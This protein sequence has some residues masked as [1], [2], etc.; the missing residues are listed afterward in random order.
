MTMIPEWVLKE[1]V[2]L[3]AEEK[4]PPTQGSEGTSY[5]YDVEMSV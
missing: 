3:A 2:E 1:D 4:C 5:L